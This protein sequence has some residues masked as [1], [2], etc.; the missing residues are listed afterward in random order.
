[1]IRKF[2]RKLIKMN[3]DKKLLLATLEILGLTW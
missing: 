3:A 1:M 2:I